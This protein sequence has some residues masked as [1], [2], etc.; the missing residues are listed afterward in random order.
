MFVDQEGHSR[1]DVRL[2]ESDDG[3]T[4]NPTSD[5]PILAPEPGWKKAFVYAPFAVTWEGKAYIFYNARDGWFKGS[6]RIG[7]AISK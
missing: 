2:Y 6:E 4:W 3:L 1:S 5:E 7:V